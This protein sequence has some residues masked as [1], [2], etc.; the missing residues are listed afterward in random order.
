MSIS[1]EQIRELANFRTKIHAPSV[2]IS[3]LLT[4]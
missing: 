4:P 3:N 2:F 1:R